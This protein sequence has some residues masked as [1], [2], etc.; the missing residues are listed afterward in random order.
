MGELFENR[1]AAQ[2]H[3]RIQDRT[4]AGRLLARM[5]SPFVPPDSLV[6]AIPAGGIPVAVE[7]ARELKI[8]LDLMIVRKIQIPGNT[9]AGFG[10]VAR[11]GRPSSTRPP[12]ETA[13]E[14][15]EIDGAGWKKT[16]RGVEAR[17]RQIPGQRPFPEVRGRTLIL[18]D[19]GLASGF[20]MGEAVRFLR[21]SRWESSCSRAHRAQ[22]DGGSPIALVEEVHCLNVRT[23]ILLRSP[24][25]TR[26][27][28]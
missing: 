21:G 5:I 27:L 2:P 22:G 24:K 3:L 13:L 6:L 18:V 10:A 19:D 11:T 8:P 20:T 9:E 12:G 23:P 28:V 25:L 26:T 16:R 14:S 17:I 15:G 7:V 4:H 1:R